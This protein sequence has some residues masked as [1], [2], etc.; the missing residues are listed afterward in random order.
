MNRQV[1]RAIAR[2]VEERVAN[3]GGTVVVV[4]SG[5]PATGKTTL[6]ENITEEL[7]RERVVTLC[8]DRELHSR[9]LREQLGVSGID[10]RARDMKRL[11]ADVSAICRGVSIPNRIYRRRSGEEPELVT[12]GT[13]DPKPI[14]LLDG[15]AWCYRDFDGM[16]DLKYLLLPYAFED[17]ERMS[18]ARDM[19]ERYYYDSQAELKHF[20]CY[21]TYFH[22]VERVRESARRIYRVSPEYRYL[23]EDSLARSSLPDLGRSQPMIPE[24]V[25][26]HEELTEPVNRVLEHREYLS[27]VFLMCKF[28]EGDP[29]FD[30]LVRTVRAVCEKR[31][32]RTV[33]A[34]ESVCTGLWDNVRAH[35]LACNLGIAVFDAM[36]GG[37]P[38]PNVYIESG[39]MLGRGK[40][41]LYLVQTGIEMP[42]DYVGRIVGYFDGS[43][44]A[45]VEETVERELGAWLTSQAM[46]RQIGS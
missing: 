1:A 37:S 14:V 9:A 25:M 27:N 31:R 39:F 30:A 35:M 2:E 42:V 23:E 38:S 34:D 16:W 15:F 43:D 18:I 19:E 3:G 22:H 28:R 46:P 40:E 26:G 7:G 33:L 10:Y 8:D 13:L 5:P 6:C 44:S 17:S 4:V 36:D 29:K 41:L 32:F 24:L 21:R 20:I 45:K 11:K 12:E